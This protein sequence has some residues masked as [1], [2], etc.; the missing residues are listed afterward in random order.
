MTFRRS[1]AIKTSTLQLLADRLDL[2]LDR[3]LHSIGGL[4]NQSAAAVWINRYPS[5]LVA[6]QFPEDLSDKLRGEF[7]YG[8]VNCFRHGVSCAELDSRRHIGQ[9]PL[10]AMSKPTPTRVAQLLAA[11]DV[12]LDTAKML[13]AEMEDQRKVREADGQPAEPQLVLV[14]KKR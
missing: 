3:L 11:L 12:E 8:W 13:R 6:F 9:L 2:I 5:D 4:L 14:P 7:E 1:V 10:A